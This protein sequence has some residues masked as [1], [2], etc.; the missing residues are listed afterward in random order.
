MKR[1]FNPS[2]KEKKKE[3]FYYKNG[4]WIKCQEAIISNLWG[5]IVF[6]NL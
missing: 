3:Q 4:V 2:F 5:N 6:S 1:K